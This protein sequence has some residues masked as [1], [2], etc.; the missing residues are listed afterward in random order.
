MNK[1]NFSIL[2]IKAFNLWSLFLDVVFMKKSTKEDIVT[3]YYFYYY[4]SLIKLKKIF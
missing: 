3:Y 4:Y 2:Q 1:A